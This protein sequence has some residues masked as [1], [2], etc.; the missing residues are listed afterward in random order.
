MALELAEVAA[1]LPMAASLALAGGISTLR[2]GRRRKELNEAMHELRRPL[3]VLT[4]ALPYRFP[5][6]A[7][8]ESSLRLATDAL[9]RLD[10]HIN[11]V[12]APVATVRLSPRPLLEEAVLR[13]RRQAVFVGGEII[14]RWSAG[15]AMVSVNPVELA[16][17]VDNLISNAIEH[18]GGKVTVGAHQVGSFFVVSVRDAGPCTDRC[19]GTRRRARNGRRGHG[20][21]LVSRFAAAH[22][23]DFDL[24]REHEGAVA[25]IRLPLSGDQDGPR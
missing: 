5:G 20:L 7:A 3:Q 19:P 10:R 9:E 23:G 8:V 2:D 22:G 24:R 25:T 16:Q 18:G 1:G 14:F 15:G 4:L 21:R 11:K 12:G 17:A 6:D 13:W